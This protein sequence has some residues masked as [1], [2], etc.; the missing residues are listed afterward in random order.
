LVVVTFLPLMGEPVYK[1]AIGTLCVALLTACS[2]PAHTLS[3]D[4]EQILDAVMFL[5]TGVEDNT[6]VGS[7]PQT[8]RREVTG[9]SIEFSTI[10]ENKGIGF[11]D[12]ETNR[13]TRQSAYVRDVQRI[14]LEGACVFH[15]EILT[16]F[17]KGNSKE[18]FSGY[19]SKSANSITFNLANASNLKLDAEDVHTRA[20]IALAGPRVACTDYGGYCENAWN[21]FDAGLDRNT[22]HGGEAENGRRQ[23]ALEFIKKV[24]PGKP[25]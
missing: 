6:Q 7:S 13:K 20:L 8:W 10:T 24:C 12:D 22:F 9:R 3:K 5:F 21:S 25:Y 17:S 18:D 2:D 14:T 1:I 11:S 16:E 19:S 23:R 15:I 4:E